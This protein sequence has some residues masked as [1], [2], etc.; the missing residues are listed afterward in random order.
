MSKIV[1]KNMLFPKSP[2]GMILRRRFKTVIVKKKGVDFTS[3]K[4][5]ADKKHCVIKRL[6]ALIQYS[7]KTRVRFQAVP[8][9]DLARTTGSISGSNQRQ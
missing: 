9:K 6:P 1:A 2:K 8:G 3:T 4:K 7:R 5:A